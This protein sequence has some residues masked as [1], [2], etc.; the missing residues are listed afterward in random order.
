MI[1]VGSGKSLS[2]VV[3]TDVT[4]RNLSDAEIMKYLNQDPN[5]KTFAVGYDPAKF[6]SASFATKIE[7]SY[8]NVL[9]GLPLETLVEMLPEV[10]YKI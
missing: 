1:N 5:F 3:K 4:W 7:G 6:F 10:G 9:W 8:T 2:R